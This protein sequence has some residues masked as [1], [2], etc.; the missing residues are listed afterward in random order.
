MNA[1]STAGPGGGRHGGRRPP[2]HRTSGGPVSGSDAGGTFIKCGSLL[3][4]TAAAI[5]LITL[6]LCAWDLI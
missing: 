5:A 3:Y 1:R 4:L 2:T 6:A